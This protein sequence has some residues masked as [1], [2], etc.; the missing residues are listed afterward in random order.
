MQQHSLSKLLR[1]QALNADLNGTREGD[2][3]PIGSYIAHLCEENI[4]IAMQCE[5]VISP[6]ELHQVELEIVHA[7]KEEKKHNVFVIDER[8]NRN[9]NYKEIIRRN[10]DTWQTRTQLIQDYTRSP[11]Y[12]IDQEITERNKNTNTAKQLAYDRAR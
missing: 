3:N 4:A 5:E 1:L 6:A 7:G 2:Y 8:I 9:D 10:Q 11:Q 12:T